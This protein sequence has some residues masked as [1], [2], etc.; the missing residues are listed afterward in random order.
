MRRRNRFLPLVQL[1]HRQTNKQT[2][3]QQSLE[4]RYN[5]DGIY[6]L[7][8]AGENQCKDLEEEL[9]SFQRRRKR[10]RRISGRYRPAARQRH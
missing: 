7:T 9:L 10:Q 6:H 5:R 1:S 4:P 8:V 2:R 3:I